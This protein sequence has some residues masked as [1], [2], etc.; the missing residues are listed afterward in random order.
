MATYKVTSSNA[1]TTSKIWAYLQIIHA[2]SENT[3]GCYPGLFISWVLP[4]GFQTNSQLLNPSLGYGSVPINPG[5]V[6][7]EIAFACRRDGPGGLPA[8]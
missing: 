1:A 5:S 2:A 8:N 6:Q 4:A 3:A 7:S